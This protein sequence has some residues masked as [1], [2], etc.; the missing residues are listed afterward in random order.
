[1]KPS[2]IFMGTPEFAVPA[3]HSLIELNEYNIKLVV[4]QPD[5]PSGRGQKVKAPPIKQLA[6][7]HGIEVV[8]PLNLKKDSIEKEK[9]LSTTCDFLI[10]AA[11]G[12][13]LPQEILDHP[14]IAP[15]NIHASLLPAYRGAAPIARAIM[16]GEEKTGVSV[17]WIVQELDMGDILYSLPTKIE[18]ND[19]AQSLHDRLAKLGAQAITACLELFK[20]QRLS[21][22]PQDPRVGSYANKL[23]KEERHIHFDDEAFFVHR[24][25]MALNPWPIA[26]V[27]FLGERLRLCRS[28][29]VGRAAEAE[30]G[31][32]IDVTDSEIIV[33]C[34]DACVGITEIQ[35]DN[36]RKMSVKDFL[37][38]RKVP[39]GLIMGV[40]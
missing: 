22:Q 8:Q 25:I 21:R 39:T 30:P 7:S 17:Q 34:Q 19:T 29:F 10:V 6:Q 13:I 3:L 38:S 35:Q 4:S 24:K 2:I 5:R 12:Q 37:K 31:T 28:H 9:I 18:E 33:A 11:F 16:E 32:V 23:S 26:E 20:N 40:K 1:M 36:K 14:R 27:Q 15:L